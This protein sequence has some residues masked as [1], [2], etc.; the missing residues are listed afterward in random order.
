MSP[1]NRLPTEYVARGWIEA[2]GLLF[3]ARHMPHEQLVARIKAQWSPGA[4][5]FCI[6]DTYA[7]LWQKPRSLHTKEAPAA[8]LLA[9]GSIYATA[10]LNAEQIERYSRHPQT[11]VHIDQGV[12]QPSALDHS[13]RFDPAVWVDASGYSLEAVKPLGHPPGKPKLGEMLMGKG[14]RAL[15]KDEKLQAT[16]AQQQII[17]SMK[18]APASTDRRGS[19]GGILFPL[20]IS[21]LPTRRGSTDS[22]ADSPSHPVNKLRP[23]S[24]PQPVKSSRPSFSEVWRRYL[25]LSQLGRLIGRRQ[26]RYLQKMVKMFEQGDLDQALKH[27]IPLSDLRDALERQN[28]ALGTPKARDNLDIEFQ[29]QRSNSA[30]G[31]S[32]DSESLLRQ[33]YERSFRRL[34]RLGRHREAGFVLAELLKEYDRAVD[35]LEQKG[36]KVMAAELAEGQQLQPAKVISQWLIAGNTARAIQIARLTRCYATAVSFLQNRDKSLANRLRWAFSQLHAQS[37]DYEQ[38]V[39]LAWPLRQKHPEILHWARQAIDQGGSVGARMLARYLS[40]ATTED[41]YLHKAQALLSQVDEKNAPLRTEFLDTIAQLPPTPITRICARMALRC[42]IGDIDQGYRKHEKKRFNAL[43]NLVDDPLLRHEAKKLQLG[44][45]VR[46]PTNLLSQREPPLEYQIPAGT[47]SA[48]GQTAVAILAKEWLLVARGESGVDIVKPDG[49]KVTTL[50]VPC[51]DIVTSDLGNR[52]LLLARRNSLWVV[53]KFELERLTAQRWLELDID[54]YAATHDGMQWLVAKESQLWLL[55]LQAEE[56]RALWSISDLPGTIIAIQRSQKRFAMLLHDSQGDTATWSYQLPELLLKERLPV[57]RE[58]VEH[59]QPM[60]IRED[61]LIAGL[62]LAVED[63]ETFA[64]F[65]SSDKSIPISLQRGE[66]IDAMWL[67][68]DWLAICSHGAD[69]KAHLHLYD[70]FQTNIIGLPRLIVHFDQA[71]DV[72]VRR[73]GET[74][75]LVYPQGNITLLSLENGSLKSSIGLLQ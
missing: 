46:T 32:H 9:Y 57:S 60:S 26:A 31:L 66:C 28:S 27:A 52:A 65:K 71:G 37:G 45:Q 21:L 35:Y 4:K 10:P 3:D 34:D 58:T 40:L 68:Q 1:H 59:Y 74:L 44:S 47:Q 69:G 18:E 23:P 11:L 56:Q 33:L 15:F 54:T 22:R 38:A 16:E 61:G 72:Y 36:E 55:D 5:L 7:L 19:M 24:G 14:N 48:A 49:I 29:R 43:L 39:E 42:L 2:A 25:L 64:L 8:P 12:F 70:L 13:T 63:R 75:V 53:Y 17:E 73:F 20:L 41:K 67:Y 6:G 50:P 30:I 62:A 51:H